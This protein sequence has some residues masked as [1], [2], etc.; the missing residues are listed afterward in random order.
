[1]VAARAY[2]ARRTRP[3]CTAVLDIYGDHLLYCE[4]GSHRI[5]RHIAQVRLLAGDHA[6]AAWHPI[7]EKRPLGRHR[8]RPDIRALGKAGGTDLFDVTNCHPLSQAR[9][10]DAVQNPSN[11]LKAAWAGKF[12]CMQEWSKKPEDAYNFHPFRFSRLVDGIRT[13]IVLCAQWQPQ[14]PLVECPHSDLLRAFCPSDM[15]HYSRRTVL[16]A[17]CQV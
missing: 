16:F 8:E 11:I 7:V 2:G 15:L 5:S 4:R 1:M 12:Q 6:K 9:S 10:R 3:Q 14:L 17:S 13:L